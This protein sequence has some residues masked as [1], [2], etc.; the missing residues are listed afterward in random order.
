M[1]KRVRIV[2][3]STVA[4]VAVA[5]LA[6]FV[7]YQTGGA[8][9]LLKSR[10]V[11]SL[12]EM[13]IRAEIADSDLALRPGSVRFEG[14]KLYPG[15]DSTPIATID[16]INVTFDITSLWSRTVELKTVELVHPVVNITFDENGLSNL[17]AIKMPESTG[18]DAESPAN[19]QATIFTLRDGQF[20]YGDKANRIDGSVTNLLLSVAP[21]AGEPLQRR[22]EASFSG[23]KLTVNDREVPEIGMQLAADVSETG[24]QVENVELTTP[25]GVVKLAGTVSSWAEMTY[26]FN[27]GSTISMDRIGAIIDP[28]AGLSGG[29]TLNGHVSGTGTKYRFD[30]ELAGN[31][32][33]VSGARID[34]LK[35]TGPV[36]GDGSAYAWGA[37]QVVASRLTMAGYDVSNLKFAGRVDGTGLNAVAN[38]AFTA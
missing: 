26:D 27:V 12:A 18:G 16:Q 2:I 9:R 24:A 3:V 15:S 6:L 11:A 38:G 17:D 32:L 29:A 20:N 25:L 30:G 5:V 28:A 37:G 35:I 1:K 21:K 23:S 10:V 8:A 22:V 31:D 34:G 14:V 36:E 19:V 4:L 7:W 13:N 33:L